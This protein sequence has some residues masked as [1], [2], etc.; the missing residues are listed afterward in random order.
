MPNPREL[1]R[2]LTGVAIGIT[3]LSACSGPAGSS[4]GPSPSGDPTHDA[5]AKIQARGT[6]ILPT[7]PKYPPSSFAVD[8]AT[9]S[10]GTRCTSDQLTRAE[11][12]GYDVAVGNLIADAIGVEPCYVVPT[13]NEMLAGHWADR[14]DIAFASIGV[15]QDR[16]AQLIFTKPYIGSPERLWVKSDSTARQMSDLNGKQVGVCTACWADLYL[17]KRLT[18]PGMQID[19]KVDNARIVGY[20]VEAAGLQDV[21]DGKLD[22]FLCADTVAQGLIDAGVPL[23][24]IEPAAYIGIPAGAI[25]RSNSLTVKPLYDL[26]NETLAARFAD[27]TLKGL[28]MKY[29]GHDYATA[30]AG[31]DP[32]SFGQDIH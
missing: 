29:F 16:M 12:D 15:E 28:S 17:Q 30:A 14:W 27:G 1:A 20:A 32:A 6:L 25:D 22:A 23:R 4:A 11:L 13:W 9:R 7:D 26:A 2:A 8:G 19:Y 31:I 10:T 24:G 5:L 3:M 18:V 21:A